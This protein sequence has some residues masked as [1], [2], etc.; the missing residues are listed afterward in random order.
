MR[1]SA[2]GSA[3]P[4]GAPSL[5]ANGQYLTLAGYDVAPGFADALWRAPRARYKVASLRRQSDC[6]PFASRSRAG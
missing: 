2:S 3:G 1:S 5:S 6:G 4:E